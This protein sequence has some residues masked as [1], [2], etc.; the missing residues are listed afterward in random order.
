VGFPAARIGDMH[1]CPMVTGVV[2]HVGGPILPPCA[3]TVLTGKL[4]QARVT[5]MCVC[6]GPPDVIVKGSA[7]VLVSKLPAARM[8]DMTAH[9]GVIVLGCFTVLIGDAGGGGGGGGAA[10]FAPP[11]T[12]ECA[13][14]ASAH[15][16]AVLANHTYGENP[17]LP[18]GYRQIDPSTDAGKAELAN[19]GLT[20]SNLAPAGSTFR[21]EIFVRDGANGPQYTVAYRGTAESADWAENG[22][23]GV[24]MQSGHYESA[25]LIGNKV[26]AASGGNV[27]FTGHSLGGGLA[28]AAAVTTGRPATTFNSAGL[29]ARTVGGYPD[30]P[31]PVDAYYVPGEVLSGVQDNRAGVLAGLTGLA[32]AIHPSLGGLLGGWITGRELGDSPILPQAYGARHRLPNAVPPGKSTLQSLNPID[33]HGMDWV[34]HGIEQ[35]QQDLGC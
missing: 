30:T 14:L 3:I 34:L 7:T 16:N 21:S 10:A 5:D 23:Q 33:R 28:S 13:A 19:L 15:D 17:T 12:P 26:S 31:V 22:R 20:P 32:T 25:M 8:T 6:V 18:P 27:S 11:P 29:S 2:P 4:P 24:G 35:Q 1:V 9:G